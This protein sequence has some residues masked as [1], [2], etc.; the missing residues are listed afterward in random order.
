MKIERFVLAVLAMWGGASGVFAQ[1]GQSM[2][3][4][5]AIEAPATV[6]SAP[7][8]LSPGGVPATLMPGPGN[9]DVPGITNWIRHDHSCS[10]N[11]VKGH[12]GEIGYEIYSNSG[13]SVPV[14]TGTVLSR[15]CQ[16]GLTL[17]GGFHTLFFNPDNTRA[18]VVDMGVVSTWNSGG[19]TDPK[20]QF[21]LSVL[22]PNATNQ[23]VNQRQSITDTIRSVNRTFVNL[24]VGREWFW[25]GDGT[26]ATGHWRA[27]VDGGGRY[28]TESMMFDLFLKH[29]TDVIG[30]AYVG[31]HIGYECPWNDLLLQVG[32][33]VEYAYTWSDILQTSTDMS[34]LNFLFTA[35]IRF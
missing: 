11:E 7:P 2:L 13:L 21:T 4:P 17:E 3:P 14:G 5:T 33:R 32:F 19:A 22:V 25:G 29:R 24:G 28:G 1:D 9:Y 6:P 23:G 31:A 20:E 35:G 18:W 12:D 8:P 34:E 27:G 30:G 16:I 26:A 10:C 15:N